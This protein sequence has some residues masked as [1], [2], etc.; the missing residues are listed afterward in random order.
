MQPDFL[1]LGKSGQDNRKDNNESE[2]GSD[3]IDSICV[4]LTKGDVTK[5]DEIL[6]G[7]TF[8]EIKPYLKFVARDVLFREAVLAFMGVKD[9]TPKES[10]ISV[11][12][13]ACKQAK[14]DIDC[15][16]CER[17]IDSEEYEK[18]QKEKVIGNAQ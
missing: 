2:E 16:T 7:F 5:R 11:Y 6:W 18:Y 12:C 14:K 8:E 10:A 4:N 17:N 9:E 13:K 3:Y 15:S 1:T